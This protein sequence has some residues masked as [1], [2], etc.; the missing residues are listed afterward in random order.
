VAGGG[1]LLMLA[2]GGLGSLSFKL[3][4][5]LSLSVTSDP[6]VWVPD[7]TTSLG[8]WPAGCKVSTDRRNK[9]GLVSIAFV[10]QGCP[11]SG[12]GRLFIAGDSHASA[13]APLAQ[14]LAALSGRDVRLHAFAG[15]GYLALTAALEADKG[16]CWGA[17]GVITA[18]LLQE[19]KP[20]DVLFLP[21]LRVPR[22]RDQW[23]DARTAFPGPPPAA[24][25]L[26]P[27]IVAEASTVLRQ[28]RQTGAT[29]VF[30]APKPVFRSPPFRCADWFNRMNPV[31]AAGFEEP[32]EELESFRRPILARMQALAR[33]VDGVSVWD[34]F[35]LLCPGDTCNAFDAGKPLVYDGDHLSA[36]GNRVLF[37][38]V[39]R[40][41]AGL[42]R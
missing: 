4:P 37:P 13:Y 40:D 12:S 39:A 33:T 42:G 24:D 15:C 1:V 2:A 18:A 5:S 35:P 32:R 26:R 11:V 34:P 20:G 17:Q 16:P 21:S 41:V 8:P 6:N 28:L 14:H 30:E 7:R 38:A 10:P 23:E 19:L 29:I 27:D 25:D 9:G 22:L 3:Q 31:C 36:Y